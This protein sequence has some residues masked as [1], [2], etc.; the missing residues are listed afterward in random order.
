MREAKSISSMTFLAQE[1]DEQ[2]FHEQKQ[3]TEKDGIEER[4][5]KATSIIS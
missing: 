1:E 2:T 5:Q 4:G 3:L